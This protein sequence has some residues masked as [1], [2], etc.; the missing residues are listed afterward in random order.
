MEYEASSRH[1]NK[2]KKI[3]KT[4]KKIEVINAPPFE[5]PWFEHFDNI[6]FST[7]KLMT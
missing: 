3:C 7:R 6:F 5:W 4:K 2:M 1:V